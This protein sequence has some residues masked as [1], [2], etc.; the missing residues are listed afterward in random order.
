MR[1]TAPGVRTGSRPF[2]F[3]MVGCLKLQCFRVRVEPLADARGSFLLHGLLRHNR[4]N[5]RG[6]V[7]L[8][9]ARRVLLADELPRPIMAVTA[10]SMAYPRREKVALVLDLPASF[11][12]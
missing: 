3:R 11:I 8:A 4:G 6:D 10:V 2:G 9:L 5:R 1:K 12:A 7:E